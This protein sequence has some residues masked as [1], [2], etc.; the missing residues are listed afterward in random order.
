MH[1]LWGCETFSTLKPKRKIMFHIIFPDICRWEM[2]STNHNISLFWR[3]R[4]TFP[5]INGLRRVKEV[6]VGLLVDDSR[7]FRSLLLRRHFLGTWTFQGFWHGLFLEAEADQHL[8]E[9]L[10]FHPLFGCADT[11]GFNF[12]RKLEGS[13]SDNN[14]DTE[15]KMLIRNLY[16]KSAH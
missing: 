5:E 9:R 8:P 7:W 16:G 6:N 2:V 4:W 10:A 12:G 14:K 3:L 11:Q 1:I 13:G 15:W